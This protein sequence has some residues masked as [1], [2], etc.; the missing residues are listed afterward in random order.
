[1]GLILLVQAFD[2]G[3]DVVAEKGE[4]N[5]NKRK[6]GKTSLDES[7]RASLGINGSGKRM[8]KAKTRKEVCMTTSSWILCL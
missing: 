1:M 5:G 4:M 7:L 3:R 2:R 6:Y 8:K